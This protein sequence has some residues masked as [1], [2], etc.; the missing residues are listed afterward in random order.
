MRFIFIELPSFD[1]EEEQ[2]ENDFERWIYVLK[3]METLQRMPFRAQKAVFEKLEKIVA[4]ASL[5][6][7]ERAKYDESL[8]ILRDRLS[9]IAYAKE[10][11]RAEGKEEGRAEGK[12]EGRAEEKAEMARNL[13]AMGVPIETIAK[14]S[15]LSIEE[16]EQL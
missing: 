2:C 10:E 13:K 14:A 12:E 3:N 7:D 11:G 16:I 6:R 1:K 9:E 4:L 15:G 5:S 8:K